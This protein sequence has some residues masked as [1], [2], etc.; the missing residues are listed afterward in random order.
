[1]VNKKTYFEQTPVEAVKKT[2]GIEVNDLEDLVT[3][4]EKG[5]TKKAGS[6]SSERV[7]PSCS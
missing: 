4:V 2:A 7:K 1:M 6:T 3:P 5:K